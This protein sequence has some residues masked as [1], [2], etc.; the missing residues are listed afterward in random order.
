MGKGSEWTRFV[1]SLYNEKKKQN[2]NY[3]F[4]QALKDAGKL[5]KKTKDVS[6]DLHKKVKKSVTG[7][8]KSKKNRTRKNRT[9]KNM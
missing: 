6:Q 9:K 3:M 5:Y 4:K 8:K 2:A 1:T 7:K